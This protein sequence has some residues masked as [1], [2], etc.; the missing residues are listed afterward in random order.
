MKALFARQV[1]DLYITGSQFSACKGK[2]AVTD[3]FRNRVSTEHTKAFLEVEGREA[4]VLCHDFMWSV[5]SENQLDRRKAPKISPGCSES[6][7]GDKGETVSVR[8]E[9]GDLERLIREVLLD[10][11]KILQCTAFI[12]LYVT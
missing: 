7:P 5:L 4:D 12:R 3:V 11:H 2:P 1:N 8:V 9:T 6:F 10:I